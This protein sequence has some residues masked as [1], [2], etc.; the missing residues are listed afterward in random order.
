[1][2]KDKL[3]TDFLIGGCIGKTLMEISGIVTDIVT[4]NINED[5][6][7]RLIS[8]FIIFAIGGI[9][10]LVATISVKKIEKKDMTSKNRQKLLKNQMLITAG[11]I[12]LFGTSLVIYTVQNN[13]I[14]IIL[15]LS[16]SAVFSFWGYAFLLSYINL[17]NNMAMINK[18]N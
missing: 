7:S 10:Y 11:A 9:G 1:M 13:Y 2:K 5:L 6:I 18:K 12:M 3:I 8:L 15:S 14:G 16:F 17:K 4:G